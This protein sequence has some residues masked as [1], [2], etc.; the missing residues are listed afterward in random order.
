MTDIIKTSD[1]A[2]TKF[3]STVE[4]ANSTLYLSLQ[5]ISSHY[6][7]RWSYAMYTVAFILNCMPKVTFIKIQ[8][9]VGDALLRRTEHFEEVLFIS[10][11]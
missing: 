2:T 11:G 4:K 8:W 9:L 7:D 6:I 10:T 1:I 5:A 3:C